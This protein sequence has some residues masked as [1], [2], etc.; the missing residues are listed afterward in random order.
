MARA[1]A[2]STY[3][4]KSTKGQII[5][6]NII[7]YIKTFL[8]GNTCLNFVIDLKKIFDKKTNQIDILN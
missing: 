5:L 4:S 8:E 6:S 3:R 7:F 2:N 1:L